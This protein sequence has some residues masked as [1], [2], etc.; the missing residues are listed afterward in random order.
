MPKKRKGGNLNKDSSECKRSRQ[1]RKIEI[2]EKRFLRNEADAQ[3]CEQQRADE[4]ANARLQRRAAD[5]QRHA[6]RR[7]GKNNDARLIRLEADAERHAKLRADEN[8]DA[9][10]KRLEGDAQRHAAQRAEENE[11]AKKR[12]LETDAQ[13]HAR[14]RADE[15]ND[16]RLKRLE[17]DAQRHALRRADENVDAR[18]KRHEADAQ[19]HAAHRAD[20]NDDARTKRVA[21]DAQKHAQQRAD[22]NDDTRTKRLETDAQTH[23][24]RRA[25]ENDDA[26]TKRL[27]IDAS[28]HAEG[29]QK[30]GQLNLH[31]ALIAKDKEINVPVHKLG[32][33]N[34]EC[35]FCKS[36]NF[37]CEK[38]KEGTFTYCCQKG[39]L[40][41][42]PIEC[43]DFLKKLYM[44]NDLASK[45]FQEH[46]RSYNSALA[47]A[48]MGAP[49]NRN[50]FD[51]EHVA[52]Y[53]LK[54]HGQYHHLTS[55]AMHPADGQAPR[56]AQLYFL[57]TEEAINHR[58]NIKAN[59]ECDSEI[60]KDLSSFMVEYNAFAQS[61]KMMR[62]VEQDLNQKGSE[63][64]NLML[65]VRKDPQHDQ[66]R[67]NAP[68]A[69][70]IAVVFRNIDGEPP[71]E[72]DIRIY[73][74]KSNDVQQISIMDKRCD[75]MCYPLLYPYGN[76]G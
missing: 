20:E 11:D 70:E 14:R 56:F 42:K 44:E 2:T 61:F 28:K 8:D 64:I 9:R 22:E 15:N 39:K 12:R 37:A 29:R 66:R 27:K 67:Y 13:G 7:A 52:P 65:S 5:A 21:T 69:N 34:V 72:R 32:R 46:I 19:R 50:P 30:A 40:E 10:K 4:N 26:R 57:D 48:S 31:D 75:P 49:G 62:Q 53:C 76:D 73:N 45:N 1:R 71:F 38:S 41:L 63:N 24:Q 51:V 59:K 68:R 18:T 47:M 6:R 43:P 35:Q 58:M 33:M 23:A 54:I 60:M 25:D 36:L 17:A 3:R 74:K 16:A 55:T